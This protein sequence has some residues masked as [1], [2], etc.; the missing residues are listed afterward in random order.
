[1]A[2]SGELAAGTTTYYS[3]IATAGTAETVTFPDRFGYVTVTNLMTVPLFVRADG[4]AAVADAADVYVVPPGDSRI[5]ANGRG[6]W[7][8]SS[9]VLAEGTDNDYFQSREGQLA[10]PGTSVS[11]I[12]ATG[13]TAGAY[14]VEAAG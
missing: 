7:Y 2:S 8:Q 12:I 5:I 4:Q 11:V 14:I 6:L 13:G 10:N 9:R 3:T 1:M